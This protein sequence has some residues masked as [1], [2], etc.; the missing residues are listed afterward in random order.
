M[1]QLLQRPVELHGVQVG[2]VVDVILEPE[3]ER[4]VGYEVRCEDQRHRFLP[5]AA[6]TAR[7]AAIA[8]DS[9]FALL[10]TDELDFYR[11]RGKTLR[12][13]RESAA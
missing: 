8:I 1:R 11:R 7:D 4:V 10:D 5:A 12:A 2:R 6:A 3:T 9:P 13:R